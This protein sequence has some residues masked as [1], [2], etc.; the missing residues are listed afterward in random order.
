[1]QLEIWGST[2]EMQEGRERSLV[3]PVISGATIL[4]K[5]QEIRCMCRRGVAKSLDRED[6]IRGVARVRE[7]DDFAV[8][9][10][11]PNFRKDG[12][13]TILTARAEQV[14]RMGSCGTGMVLVR[15]VALRDQ[16]AGE[17]RLLSSGP[18]GV[19]RNKE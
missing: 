18:R 8:Q 19:R 12:K 1:M 15:V 7:H 13:K 4:L 11:H 14:R 17:R 10:S 5:L 2:T 6:N 3:A 16:I 9:K